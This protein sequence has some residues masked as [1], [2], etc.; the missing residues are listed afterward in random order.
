MAG[1][2]SR[3]TTTGAGLGVGVGRGEGRFTAGVGVGAAGGGGGGGGGAAAVTYVKTSL[4][5]IGK[6]SVA[7]SKGRTTTAPIPS[8]CTAHEIASGTMS[9]GAV[10]RWPLTIK[11]NMDV[12]LGGPHIQ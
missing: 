7:K 1:G 2:S 10:L 5:T 6:W 11:S 9:R 4:G 12:L 8:M 3:G